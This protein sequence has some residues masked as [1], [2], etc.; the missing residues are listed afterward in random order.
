MFSHKTIILT[1]LFLLSIIHFGFTQ[2]SYTCKEFKSRDPEANLSSYLKE[3]T[4]DKSS[5]LLYRITN[6][7]SMSAIDLAVNDPIIR[8]KILMFGLTMWIDRYGKKKMNVGLKFPLGKDEFKEVKH[9]DDLPVRTDEN[10][11]HGG[12]KD[13]FR[14]DKRKAG[15]QFKKVE[16]ISFYDSL[17]QVIDTREDNSI[18]VW[19]E[20]ND[21]DMMFCR[22]EFPF[23]KLGLNY[24]LLKNNKISIGFVTGHLDTD[25]IKA[26][27]GGNHPGGGPPGNGQGPPGSG[28]RPSGGPHGGNEQMQM[29]QKM[30]E[31]TRC[32][33]RKIQLF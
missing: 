1:A 23:E 29:M 33:V 26:A 15:E 6:N 17:C 19:I 21:L 20:F 7:E 27:P 14:D 18:R 25:D 30:S 12:G 28:M 16:I 9:H 2:K 32:W 8:R 11:F 31:T 4:Y 3:M 5:G 22:I 24:D 10:E 13:G